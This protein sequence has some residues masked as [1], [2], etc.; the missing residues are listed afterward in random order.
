MQKSHGL[1]FAGISKKAQDEL[2]PRDQ[3]MQKIGPEFVPIGP[4]GAHLLREQKGIL[5][6]A[7]FPTRVC[8]SQWLGH[9]HN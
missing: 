6:Q 4:G 9:V 3:F 1:A 8:F 2:V 5:I 7:M